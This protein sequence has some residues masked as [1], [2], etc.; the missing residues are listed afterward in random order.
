M[1]GALAV[2]ASIA[3]DS[4]AGTSIPLAQ[5]TCAP[6]PP[7]PRRDSFLAKCLGDVDAANLIARVEVA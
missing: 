1:A 3:S 5:A 4:G 6:S 7:P 2:L